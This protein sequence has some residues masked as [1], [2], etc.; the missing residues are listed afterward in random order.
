VG[1]LGDALGAAAV[2]LPAVWVLTGITVAIYGIA[3]RFTQ[4]AWGVLSV[5]L[6]IFFVGSLDVLPQWVVDVVPFVHPPKLPG[7]AFEAAPLLWL[8]GV[9]AVLLAVGVVAFRRRDLR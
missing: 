6:V 3:P 4:V 7:S 1:K 5:M 9:A 8:L 2:Q